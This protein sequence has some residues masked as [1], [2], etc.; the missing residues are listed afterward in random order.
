[1]MSYA[2]SLKIKAEAELELRRRR[3]LR[4]LALRNLPLSD[5]AARTK[6]E[7]PIGAQETALEPFYLWP[8][9]AELLDTMDLY[10]LI[11]V[12]KARQLGISWLACLYTLRLC[13]L[14]PRQP[15][16]TISR[17]QDDAD[18]LIH[19]IS[20]MHW[21]HS[22]RASTFPRL[23][24]DNTTNLEWDNG[25]TV[26]S[27]AATKHAGRGHTAS[28]VILDEWAF[29]AW[30]SET[31][32]SVKPTIDAGGKLFIISS[33]DGLGTEYH[34]FWQSAASG[35][36]GY[37][38]VFLD[39]QARPD[40]GNGWRDQKL[41]E[42]SGD[43]TTIYREYPANDIEA[44]T[45]AAGLVYDV[46]SDGPQDG[47]V[48]T[49][50]EFTSDGGPVY[51][52]VDDGYAGSRDDKTG[53]FTADSHPRVFLLIQ[54][55]ADGRLCVFW[56]DYRIRVFP[57]P[58]IAD[59]L[60]LPYPD[61][62]YVAFDNSS[63]E[64]GGRLH[65]A[66]LYTRRKPPSVEDSIKTTRRMLAPDQ[67]GVR[68][69]LVHPRCKHLRAEMASYRYDQQTEKPVKEFDHGPDALRYFAWTKRLED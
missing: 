1:M 26:V 15:A 10:R 65:N 32:A 49:L 60:A 7:V 25:S 13:T 50:A 35:A 48:S 58:H 20:L 46:W 42:A 37:T 27:L 38:P 63:A 11:V 39:W 2:P 4:Q 14:W 57:D 62:E 68:R 12:L 34:R 44:F 17:S 66:G 6:I 16:L 64:L 5:F 23:L 41:I 19:R 55:R 29:Y 51:W 33:A 54:E 67:N 59:M 45:H 56:E 30:P 47:N 3:R 24:A 8:K 22:D 69:I 21:Q 53:Y 31:L 9:Q 18:N 36:N 43:T 40:R 52:A 28:L 61:P